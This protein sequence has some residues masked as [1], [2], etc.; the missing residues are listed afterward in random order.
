[1]HKKPVG[2]DGTFDL[3]ATTRLLEGVETKF[4]QTY[5]RKNKEE[6]IDD[7]ESAT[8]CYLTLDRPT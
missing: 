5:V 8:S 7:D 4:G 3:A 6:V 1:M 2:G